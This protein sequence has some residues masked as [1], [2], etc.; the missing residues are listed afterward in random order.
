MSKCLLYYLQISTKMGSRG[1]SLLS[2]RGEIVVYRAYTEGRF[3]T[4][5]SR[6]SGLALLATA[7]PLMNP[8]CGG[9]T[10]ITITEPA[11]SVTRDAYGDVSMASY[12]KRENDGRHPFDARWFLPQ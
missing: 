10:K 12:C 11:L 4:A 8:T 7:G 6:G 9:N 2:S 3:S 5:V 1:G